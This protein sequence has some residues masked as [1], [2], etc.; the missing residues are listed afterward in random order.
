M[1]KEWALMWSSKLYLSVWIS[2]LIT[3][4]I[5][6]KS[7]CIFLTYNETRTDGIVLNDWVLNSIAP[8]DVS[9]PLFAITWICIFAGLPIALRTPKRAMIV[10]ISIILIGALR[11][12]CL[13]V[14]PLS[15]PFGIIPLRDTFLE[16]SFYSEQVL[17]KDLFFSGH[18]ANLA[19]LTFLVD[20]KF[21]KYILGICTLIIGC[22][23]LKQHVHYT[24]DVVVAPFAAYFVYK[25]AV[26]VVDALESLLN[27]ARLSS[28]APRKVF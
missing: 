12:L 5:T 25:M 6:L 11:S 24:I 26:K 10:F 28:I 3:V 20:L 16:N 14:V 21:I 17:V 2:L 1:R 7:I 15:P 13:Y 23:L 8:L 4:L 18:T 19:L 22:L 9:T 27:S